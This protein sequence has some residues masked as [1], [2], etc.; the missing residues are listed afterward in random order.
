MAPLLLI[1]V[2]LFFFLIIPIIIYNG[3]IHKRNMVDNAFASIDAMLK[4][5]Y[6]LIP[7][8]VNTVKTYMTHEKETL[9]KITELRAKALANGDPDTQAQVD[10]EMT[11]L[12]RSIMVAVENYPQLKANENFMQLQASLNNIEEQIAAA[13]RAYNAAVT[14][15]N[16][17]IQIFP[18]SIIANMKH[19]KPRELFVIPAE[20]RKNVDVGSL[21]NS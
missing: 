7:N 17:A 10:Q 3:L 13:R 8:L 5:R 20:E 15:Y 18:N 16:T 21:F 4:K 19:F 9:T 11:G 2:L 6:D 1:G 12:M 14:T